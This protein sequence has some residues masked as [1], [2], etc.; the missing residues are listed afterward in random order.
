[1]PE[2]APIRTPVETPQRTP[3]TE[4]ERRA[5]PERLCP[6]QKETLTRTIGPILP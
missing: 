6:N 5:D 3:E 4:R 2:Q 1:M